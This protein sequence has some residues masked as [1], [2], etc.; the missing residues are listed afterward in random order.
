MRCH[1][2]QGMVFRSLPAG[3]ANNTL[4]EVL[5]LSGST[6]LTGSLPAEYSVWTNLTVF[7]CVRWCY[8]M[9]ISIALA[10]CVTLCKLLTCLQ[11]ADLLKSHGLVGS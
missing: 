4:L 3:L 11:T 8:M 2:I 10:P 5:D 7:R 9:F 6:V 1:V